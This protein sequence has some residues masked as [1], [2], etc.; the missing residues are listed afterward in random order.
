VFPDDIITIIPPST[1][2]RVCG[3]RHVK[4]HNKTFVS[5]LTANKKVPKTQNT[6]KVPGV[7]EYESC[8]I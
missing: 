3:T 1:L 8:T 6:R 4:I 5:K 7:C 2:I